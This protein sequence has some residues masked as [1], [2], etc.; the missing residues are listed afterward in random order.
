LSDR[1]R[2]SPRIRGTDMPRWRHSNKSSLHDVRKHVPARS[3][4]TNWFFLRT[5][6]ARLVEPARSPAAPRARGRTKGKSGWRQHFAAR[7]TRQMVEPDGIEL[8]A[9]PARSAWPRLYPRA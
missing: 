8:L 2:L 9:R 1:G 3:D 5:S 6:V 4:G 7:S